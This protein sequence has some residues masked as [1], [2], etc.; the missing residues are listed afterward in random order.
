MLIKGKAGEPSPGKE[1]YPA[2]RH[3]RFLQDLFLNPD[4]DSELVQAAR[5]L[6]PSVS[7]EPAL[8]N[9]AVYA[10]IIEKLNE[11]NRDL[12]LK[13]KLADATVTASAAHNGADPET[14]SVER[15]VPAT[16][17]ISLPATRA[18][19]PQLAPE[20]GE[21]WQQE[22][23]RQ[24]EEWSLP[25]QVLGGNRPL[26]AKFRE[27]TSYEVFTE[28]L[29]LE[30]DLLLVTDLAGELLAFS[31]SY[32]MALSNALSGELRHRALAEVF[33]ETA[34]MLFLNS[35]ADRSFPVVI[36]RV[37][38]K[39]TVVTRFTIAFHQEPVGYL[40]QMNGKRISA[41]TSV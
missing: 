3:F 31:G 8:Q 41:N 28:W 38:L 1:R 22:I 14:D 40:F 12:Q 37:L 27:F 32:R 30:Q 9:Q 6:K 5:G 16:T 21:L 34:V 10:A 15:S 20:Q 17:E 19:L 13:L 4:Q 39:E 33:E 35:P 36:D 7:M 18:T 29:A 26:S 23:N 25:E 11:E 2:R 24:Y